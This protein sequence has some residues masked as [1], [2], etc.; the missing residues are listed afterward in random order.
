LLLGIV[1]FALALEITDPPGPGLDPDALAYMGAAESVAAHAEYRVPT[2]QWWSADSTGLLAHFPPA[3][4]TAL[5]IPVRFGMAPTQSARL[6]QAV[7]AFVTVATLVLLVSAATSPLAGIFLAVALFATTA[8]HEVH[9]SV[10]SEPLFLACTALTLA[11]MTCAPGRP[12]RAGLPAALGIMTRYAGAALV[13]AVALWSLLPHGE[14]DRPPLRTRIRRALVAVLPALVLQG[15]WVMR[16]RGLGGTQA[17]RRFALYGELGPTLRQ[18]GTTLASWLVP[19]PGAASAPIPHRAALATAAGLV[20]LALVCM[21]ARRAW[22]DAVPPRAGAERRDELARRLLAATATLVVCYLGVIVASRLLAD[23]NIPFDERILSPFLLLAMVVAATTLALWWR[24][25][26]FQLAR[27]AVAA[28][29]LGWWAA[30]ASTTRG[31]VEYAL[32]WGS[33]FAGH[34]WRRSELLDWARHDD[35]AHPLY[36]NWPAAVFFHLHRPSRT[37]P[38]L[39]DQRALAAFADTLRVRDGRV[40]VFDVAGGELVPKDSLARRR[41]MRVV[42]ELQDGVVL[43]PVPASLGAAATA[44]RPTR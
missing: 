28:A 30:S 21:G 19:D 41:G 9:A 31:E 22:A 29:L 10:L 36:T 8:M 40:L 17:I 37:V 3:Y 2:S 7:A 6:V 25:A 13:G 12:L 16:T 26:R 34:Q 14:D 23:P 39:G 24:D 15:A 44:R 42:A 35:A 18:G 5:V 38:P 20:L 11:A 27:V 1:A 4:S 33:D 43:A 32:E